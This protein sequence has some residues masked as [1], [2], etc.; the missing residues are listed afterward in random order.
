MLG[1]LRPLSLEDI[2]GFLEDEL[3]YTEEGVGYKLHL[4]IKTAI[5]RFFVQSSAVTNRISLDI[6]RQLNSS[7]SFIGAMSEGALKSVGGALKGIS[8]LKPS[9]I[10]GTIFAARDV[11]GQMTGVAIKFKPW[12]TFKLAGNISMW[13]GP[14]G[15][16]FSLG[17]DVYTA[18]KAHELE[19]ELKQV[20]DAIATVIKGAFKDIYELIGHDEKMFDFFAPQ[21][22]DFEKIVRGMSESAE[23]IRTNRMKVMRVQQQLNGLALQRL[24]RT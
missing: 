11:L 9:V 3:G 20:R 14:A 15:A 7:E 18:Y 10:L 21:L 13:A 24:G 16:A 23:L 4:K 6:S 22:K 5:D 1:S 19:Q 12:E 2:R 17:S 8:K